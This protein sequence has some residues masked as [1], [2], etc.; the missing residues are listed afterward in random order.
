MLPKL[1]KKQKFGITGVSGIIVGIYMLTILNN[2][3]G[4]ILLV[5]GTIFL[6]FMKNAKKS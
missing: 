1:T 3:R 4:W 6:L 2:V 5:I